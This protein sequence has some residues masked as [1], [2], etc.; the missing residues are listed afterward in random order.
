M[1]LIIRYPIL[2]MAITVGG[3]NVIELRGTSAN[4]SYIDNVFAVEKMGRESLQRV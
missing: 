2:D 3:K 1:K 4:S